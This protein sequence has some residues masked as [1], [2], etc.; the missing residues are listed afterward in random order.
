VLELGCGGGRITGHLLALGAKVHGL[1]ISPAMVEYCRKT[2]PEGTFEV[3]DLRDLG[4]VGAGY[5]AVVAGF[6]VLDVLDDAERR[7]VLTAVRGLL[8]PGGVIV[9]SSHNRAHAPKIP[10]PLQLV[11]A[12]DAR[13]A[14][15]RAVRLPKILLNRRRS[16][17]LEREE[18]GYA[19]LANGPGDYEL[20]HYHID[21]D[22]QERQFAELGYVLL[23]CVDEEGRIVPPGETAPEHSELH[24]VARR[25]D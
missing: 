13:E 16:R 3:R 2:Y 6:N 15:R 22:V 21:R 1:D 5:D 10:S 7:E 23:E 12:E 14:L 25:V 24:Y 19:V 9:M 20:L 4:D 11:F 18:A 8:A 17:R